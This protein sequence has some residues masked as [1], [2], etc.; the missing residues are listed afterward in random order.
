MLPRRNVKGYLFYERIISSGRDQKLC[1]IDSK[2][3]GLL[4]RSQI[5]DYYAKPSLNP[6]LISQDVNSLALSQDNKNI[7]VGTAGGEIYLLTTSDPKI[8]Q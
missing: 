7:I 6:M 1:I 8:Q 5:V 2:S 3:Y 4:W